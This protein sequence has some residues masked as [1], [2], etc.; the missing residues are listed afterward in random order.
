MTP[1]RPVIAAQKQK[2]RPPR[3]I[4]N[5]LRQMLTCCQFINWVA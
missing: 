1:G 3:C 2:K 4:G 5:D